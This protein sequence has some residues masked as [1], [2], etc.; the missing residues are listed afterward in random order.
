MNREELIREFFVLIC[1]LENI[2]TY[3]KKQ[4]NKLFQGLETY[5]TDELK[6]LHDQFRNQNYSNRQVI[7]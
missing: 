6:M 4:V 1:F 2:N 7:H 3:N 5:T